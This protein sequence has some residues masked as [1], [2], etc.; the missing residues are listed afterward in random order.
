MIAWMLRLH[1]RAGACNGLARPRSLPRVSGRWFGG[2]WRVRAGSTF[3]SAIRS[4]PAE[5]DEGSRKRERNGGCAGRE[6]RSM[7]GTISS[8]CPSTNLPQPT[9]PPAVIGLPSTPRQTGRNIAASVNRRRIRNEGIFWHAS[10]MWCGDES[11]PDGAGADWRLCGQRAVVMEWPG[12][13]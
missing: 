5:P 7:G 9:P 10:A 2:R 12:W 6:R 4:G 3:W 8:R 1:R 13:V 11:G